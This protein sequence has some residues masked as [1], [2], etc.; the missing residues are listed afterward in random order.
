MLTPIG[1]AIYPDCTTFYH[2]CT[3][4]DSTGTAIFTSFQP[5]ILMA[6]YSTSLGPPL[7]LTTCTRAEILGK[8]ERLEANEQYTEV[9]TLKRQEVDDEVQATRDENKRAGNELKALTVVPND[10]TEGKIS[11]EHEYYKGG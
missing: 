5:Y 10:H 7:V 3:M 1:T 2:N 6:L 4:I 9:L 11:S 8:I